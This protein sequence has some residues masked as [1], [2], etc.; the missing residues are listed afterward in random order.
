MRELSHRGSN[1]SVE[2]PEAP[3]SQ[4]LPRLRKRRTTVP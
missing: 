2:Y 3:K 4:A 1:R